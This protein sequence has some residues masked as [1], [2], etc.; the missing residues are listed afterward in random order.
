MSAFTKEAIRRSC[1]K[2]MNRRPYKKITVRAIC[3]DCG[4]NRN[5]FYYHYDDI[6]SLLNEIAFELVDDAMK[7]YVATDDITGALDATIQFI[8]D[9][10]QAVLSIYN[11]SARDLYE[12]HLRTL[13]WYVVNGYVDKKFKGLRMGRS[14]MDDLCTFLQCELFGQMV[15][16]LDNGLDEPSVEIFH[17]LI[18]RYK[19]YERFFMESLTGMGP[20]SGDAER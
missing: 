4:I 19:E 17:R 2:L 13:C 12:K 14:Q 10:R 6:P 11:S 5:T 9:N 18:A 1:L 20:G 8:V 7:R 15:F 16:W 3:E